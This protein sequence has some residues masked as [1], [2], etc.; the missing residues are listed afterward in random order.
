M[1][2]GRVYV[3]T[4]TEWD[5]VSP[6]AKNKKYIYYIWFK[7]WL[8]LRP[9]L[10]SATRLWLK[11][12]RCGFRSPLEEMP[13]YFL[14]FLFLRSGT[15]AKVRYWV[16]SLNTQCLK[17]FGGKWGTEYLITMFLLPNLLCAGYSVK[18]IWFINNFI[19]K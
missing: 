12:D 1:L 8:Q 17:K 15:K 18:L 14:I 7:L 9:S 16:L 4:R 2:S 10:P 19:I 3:V 13:H 6:Y 11:R 5:V